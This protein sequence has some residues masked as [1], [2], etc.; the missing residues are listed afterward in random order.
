MKFANTKII[1]STAATLIIGVATALAFIWGGNY[2]TI[3]EQ[4]EQTQG[5][6]LVGS[7]IVYSSD[8]ISGHLTVHVGDLLLGDSEEVFHINEIRKSEDGSVYA[9]VSWKYITRYT[10]FLD[11]ESHPYTNYKTYEL[12]AF[13]AN[14]HVIVEKEVETFYEKFSEKI[15]EMQIRTS[16]PDTKTASIDLLPVTNPTSASPTPQASVLTDKDRN[17]APKA[18]ESVQQLTAT[19][20]SVITPSIAIDDFASATIRIQN[21]PREKPRSLEEQ[22]S[23]KMLHHKK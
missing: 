19:P 17:A 16:V 9:V 2:K 20:Q 5:I 18:L 23:D 12:T 11:Y 6:R 22:V 21:G 15:S 13:I 3:H 10:T 1:T 14:K 8:D 7:A 4:S